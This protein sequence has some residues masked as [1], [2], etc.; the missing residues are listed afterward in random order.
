MSLH[1]SQPF[2]SSICKLSFLIGPIANL[3]PD[4]QANR[5]NNLGIKGQLA[6]EE[7]DAGCHRLLQAKPKE[8]CEA[9]RWKPCRVVDSL[10]L[11]GG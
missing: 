10:Y 4:P 11:F 9:G 3:T 1:T 8:V 5:F 7:A 2:D 6:S